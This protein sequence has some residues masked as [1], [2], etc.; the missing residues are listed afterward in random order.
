MTGKNGRKERRRVRKEVKR[1][2]HPRDIRRKEG[3]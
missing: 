2:S 3:R 1:R